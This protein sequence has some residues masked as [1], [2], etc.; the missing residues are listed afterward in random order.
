MAGKI[1]KVTITHPGHR[2]DTV[3]IGTTKDETYRILGNTVVGFAN[4]WA[5]DAPIT[6]MYTLQQGDCVYI[7]TSDDD[8]ELIQAVCDL[9]GDDIEKL[10]NLM[11]TAGLYKKEDK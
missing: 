6:F 5:S 11:I 10:R 3:V 2:E 8:D 9:E 4:S 1:K 7:G